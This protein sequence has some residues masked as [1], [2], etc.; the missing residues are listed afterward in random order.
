MDILPDIQFNVILDLVI[1]MSYSEIGALLQK[2]N[3]LTPYQY[4]KFMLLRQVYPMENSHS[5][6][7]LVI[8]LT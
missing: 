8:N 5:T 3:R 2:F 4:H 7:F 6:E 1:L